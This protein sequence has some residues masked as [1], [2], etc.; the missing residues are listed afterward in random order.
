MALIIGGALY[1]RT[2]PSGRRTAATADPPKPAGEQVGPTR[3][4]L[5]PEWGVAQPNSFIRGLIRTARRFLWVANEQQFFVT[6]LQF[7]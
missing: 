7:I 3:I 6:K 5:L 2:A 1:P 4:A